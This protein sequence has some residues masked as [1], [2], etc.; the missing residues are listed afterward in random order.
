MNLD[1]YQVSCKM[2]IRI[3]RIKHLKICNVLIAIALDLVYLEIC[4]LV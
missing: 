4:N 3:I 1:A 2:I